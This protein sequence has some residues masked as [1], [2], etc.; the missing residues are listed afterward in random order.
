MWGEA[1]TL[2]QVQ[3]Y[4]Y[5]GFDSADVVVGLANISVYF[6]FDEGETTGDVLAVYPDK[7]ETASSRGL[8]PAAYDAAAGAVA[9][10]KGPWVQ[11]E[12][13]GVPG[14]SKKVLGK[15]TRLEPCVGCLNE[16]RIGTFPVI[17]NVMVYVNANGV[18]EST[19]PTVPTRVVSSAPF[20]GGG[21]TAV[22]LG[23]R[24]DT[25]E[26]VLRCF[27]DKSD[28]EKLTFEVVQAPA[29]GTLV[30]VTAEKIT[31]GPNINRIQPAR[32]KT[33]SVYGK[34]P[35]AEVT[36]TYVDVIEEMWH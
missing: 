23:R 24:Q 18:E 26:V 33:E 9:G 11:C 30:G 20:V 22:V 21:E 16:G 6:R 34:Y 14:T 27:D 15:P 25:T 32:V 8:C 5:V 31:S 35:R 29:L 17:K 10:S 7:G 36:A 12:P 1:R 13:Y 19:L 3:R 2:E 28:G 4:M